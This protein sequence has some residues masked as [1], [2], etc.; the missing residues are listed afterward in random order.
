MLAF[1][2]AVPPSLDLGVDLLVEVRHRAR[3]HPRAPQGFG[4][5]L[6]A[7]HRDARQIHLDQR[8]LDRAL[9]A[10]V[11]LD[12]RGL[13]GLAPQ[14]WY[15][16]AYFAGAGLQRSFV[17]ASSGVLPRL[18]P[19]ITARATELVCLSIQHRIQCLFHRATNHLTQMVSDPGFIDLD[20]LTHRLLVTH[21]LLLHCMK[22]PSV[23]KVRKI[24]DV[25]TAAAPASVGA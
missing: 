8:F 14:L 23:P 10:A 16:E 4:D 22:K 24:L 20:H 6:H 2:A 7:S 19:F 15:L 21:R 18:A 13:E 1:D 17:A 9:P 12:D 3:A 25:T 11:P 5:V